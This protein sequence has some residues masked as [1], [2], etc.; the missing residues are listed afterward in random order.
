MECSFG[1][2]SVMKTLKTEINSHM[3]KWLLSDGWKH[4]GFYFKKFHNKQHCKFSKENF[5]TSSL[6]Q[7]T[8]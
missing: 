3:Y 6:V 8:K 7:I 5:K 1:T 4:Q 2:Q